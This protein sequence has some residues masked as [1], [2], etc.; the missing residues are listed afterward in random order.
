LVWHHILVEFNKEVVTNS[1]EG[2]L[3]Q[4][5]WEK[6]YQ[7]E[8]IQ[9]QLKDGKVYIYEILFTFFKFTKSVGKNIIAKEIGE[10]V[11]TLEYYY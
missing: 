7:V 6:Y 4:I 5:T 2:G 11:K 8:T 9:Q 1:A 10:G 3:A